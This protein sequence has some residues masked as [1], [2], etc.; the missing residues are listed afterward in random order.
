[1]NPPETSASSS[2]T[3]GNATGTPSSPPSSPLFQPIIGSRAMLEV[4][5]QLT[6]A[7][8][9][10]RYQQGE[11]L[12]TVD[13]L[14][15]TMHVSKPTIGEAVRLLAEEGVVE[16]RR[17]ANGGIVVLSSAIPA[18][19]LKLTRH[20]HGRTLG[21]VVEAR[22]PIEIEL[23]RLAAVRATD[24]DYQELELANKFLVESR[25][26]HDEWAQANNVFHACIGRAARNQPLAHFQY[27]LLQELA[28]LVEGYSEGYA[29]P[30][31]TI[32]EHR[33]TLA[34]LRTGDP[35]LAEAA[36]DEHLRELEELA[37]A[38]DSARASRPEQPSAE[39][40]VRPAARRPSR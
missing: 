18:S 35:D 29:D 25:G 9:S 24:R 14:A 19:L 12:P 15:K 22:R 38:F 17:G 34:A 36:M 20:R 11:R 31:R 26:K 6:M 33:D 39:R 5:D 21:E 28:L 23:A 8:M 30:D 27:E 40:R 16:A 13:E 4:A 10:G 32:R 1:M 7:I 2:E 37:P 3:P